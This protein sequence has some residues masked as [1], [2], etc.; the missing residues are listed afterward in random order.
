MATLDR[1]TGLGSSVAIKAPCVVA[2][3]VNITLTGLQTID[4]ITVVQDDRVLVKNQTSGYLNGIYIASTGVW[5]RSADFN[6]NRDFVNGTIVSVIGGSAGVGFYVVSFSGSTPVL[7]STPITFA[8]TSL[9]S[10]AA[11]LVILAGLFQPL[12]ADLTALAAISA[13]GIFAHTGAGSAAARVIAGTANQITVTNGDGVAGDPTIAL[14]G[15]ASSLQ[16][17]VLVAGDLLYATADD[18]LTRLAIGANG[19]VL[20]SNGTSPAWAGSPIIGP[21]GGRLTLQTAT[22]VATVT[23]ST[24]VYYT[25]CFGQFCPIYDGATMTMLSF[26]GELSNVISNSAT[27]KSGPAAAA[28]SSNYDLFVWNDAGTFRLTRGPAWTSDTARGS[29]AGTTEIT[30]VQGVYLNTNAITNGP[31]AQR[32]TYVGTVRT[33]ASAQVEIAQGVSSKMFVWNRYNR[34]PFST[35]AQDL[36]DTWT[37]TTAVWRAVG[38]TDVSSMSVV[39]GLLEDSA[40]AIHNALSSNSTAAVARYS[41]I[42]YNSTS[43]PASFPSGAFVRSTDTAAI[44]ALTAHTSTLVKKFAALGLHTFNA[45]EYS[46]ATGTTTWY[47]DNGAALLQTGMIYQGTF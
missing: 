32:G 21:A 6:D 5:A 22:P 36:T 45:L 31:A 42:G 23:T 18:V 35:V 12:D 41:A 8:I 28:N 30:M 4:G 37:Y 43:A 1:I 25:P 40:T 20:T 29:G 34:I 9:A 2:T 24:A 11:L 27:G 33:N 13:T 14:A 10:I 17:L 44:G 16:G 7:D 39:V 26:G 47:G 38:G 46:V 19:T 15:T 3:T